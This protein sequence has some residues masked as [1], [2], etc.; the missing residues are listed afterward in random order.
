[1]FMFNSYAKLFSDEDSIVLYA[2]SGK[3]Q[4]N[5]HK[6]SKTYGKIT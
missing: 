6:A 1:M 2:K 5:H 4:N 3:P